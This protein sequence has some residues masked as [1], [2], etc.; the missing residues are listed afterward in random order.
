MPIQM[1][2]IHS[3]IHPAANIVAKTGGKMRSN[4]AA[5]VRDMYST[6]INIVPACH[7]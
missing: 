3:H 4:W 2:E 5:A 7:G 1:A 6:L